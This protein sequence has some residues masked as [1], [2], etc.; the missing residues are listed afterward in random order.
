MLRNLADLSRAS[1]HGGRRL[2]RRGERVASRVY[3]VIE[4]F[5]L[6]ENSILLIFAVIIGLASA[7]GVILFYQ[8]IDV[9]YRALYRWTQEA[10]PFSSLIAYR[11]LLTGLALILA[12][13]VMRRFAPGE[14]GLTVPDVQLRVARQ[15]GDVPLK[16][17]LVRTAASALTIGGG[18]SAGSEGPIAVLGAGIGSAISGLFRFAATRTTVLVA[19][20]VAAGISAAFNAP[21]AGAFFALEEILGTLGAGAF[22]PVVVAS[23]VAAVASRA[24]F[25]NHPAFPMPEEYGY[26]LAREVV[27]FYPLLGVVTGLAGAAFVRL[28]FKVGD[29][30]SRLRLNPTAVAGLGGLIVG[31][32]V[33]LSGGLLLGQ[34]HLAF[35]LRALT[36]LSWYVLA[37]LAFAKMLS[38]SLTLQSGGSG[39]LFAPTL[40]VG[41][42]VGM[43]F[44]A[45]LQWLLP[46]RGLQ[47]EPYA[48][49]GMGALVA[50]ALGAPLTGILL[51]FEI[52]GDY[53]IML[54]LMVTVAIA[55]VVARR[56]DR[57]TLYSGWLRRRG[58]HIAH[59][60]SQD[61]LGR[62][63]VADAFERGAVRFAEG[64]PLPQLLER[65][66]SG[67]Q[68]IFP[69]V[70][71]EGQFIGVVTVHDL[72]RLARDEQAVRQLIVAGDLATAS[73]TILPEDSLIAA[74]R[75]MGQRGVAALP[76]VRPDGKLLGLL[77]RGHVLAAYDREL[78][79]TAGR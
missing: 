55:A 62:L 26:V 17:T 28:H 25:G 49:V 15:G 46:T 48:L 21:L 37:A 59:G 8:L 39:G 73:E 51:V 79:D 45:L 40:F 24:V 19:A 5:G 14:T 30:I 34:G 58:E 65:L 69:V 31:T 16:P 23:V 77:S 2:L 27:F 43:S 11:P 72:A 3:A 63:C 76:V 50:S 4:R 75:R 68:E 42:A 66:V 9:A 67:D 71:E 53:A 10:L 74:M 35:D 61:V 7:G 29:A 38:T 52:T 44:G 6:S 13:T 47:V 36:R 41:G 54:P 56:I 22:P 33:V 64:E 57:D 18:G 70:D 32:L 20:G 12:H 78:L 60:A 1:T